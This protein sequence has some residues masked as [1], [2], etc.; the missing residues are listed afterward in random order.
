MNFDD[1]RAIAMHPEGWTVAT[2]WGRCGQSCPCCRSS[3][4]TNEG[5]CGYCDRAAVGSTKSVQSGSTLGESLS[6]EL[7]IVARNLV[8]ESPSAEHGGA[9]QPSAEADRIARQAA[10]TD[11]RQLAKAA[12]PAPG[13]APIAQGAFSA[14]SCSHSYDFHSRPERTWQSWQEAPHAQQWNT[15]GWTRWERWCYENNF[16]DP[17]ELPED[18]FHPL[19]EWYSPEPPHGPLPPPAAAPPPQ[20][21]ESGNAWVGWDAAPR[22]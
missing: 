1:I 21:P 7:E 3:T 2:H 17:M 8:V 9:P 11:D 4:E 13:P 14:S 15:S 6:A 19:P 18:W 16:T 20:E 10:M 12:M 22:Q 5:R